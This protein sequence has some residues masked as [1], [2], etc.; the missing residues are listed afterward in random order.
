[1]KNSLFEEAKMCMEEGET[2]NN[3]SCDFRI[4][5]GH[6]ESHFGPFGWEKVLL[7]EKYLEKLPWKKVE[8]RP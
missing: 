8:Y 2:W 3:G 4:N 6:L 5:N 1:M 7:D